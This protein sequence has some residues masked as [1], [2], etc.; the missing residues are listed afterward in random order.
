[1]SALHKI[2][3]SQYLGLEDSPCF[4][5]L[6][7]CNGKT[8]LLKYLSQQVQGCLLG[9]T[10]K[11]RA[12]SAEQQALYPSFAEFYLPDALSSS[13]KPLANEIFEALPSHLVLRGELSDGKYTCPAQE[14]FEYFWDS[15][16]YTKALFEADGSR[17]LPLKAYKDYEP[18]IDSRTT[19]TISILPLEAFSCEISPET[20]CR[21]ELF[22][23]R[24]K[25]WI[26]SNKTSSSAL[27]AQLICDTKCIFKDAR[28][29]KI[30]L[31]N[32]LDT[33]DDRAR[34]QQY[35]DELIS[36]LKALQHP[37]DFDIIFA[38]IQAEYYG[39]YHASKKQD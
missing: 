5:S 34:A 21:Y 32:K 37:Q 11:M 29:K 4:I 14:L 20:V 10:T 25:A 8:S 6:M 24:Y 19:H 27:I 17:G 18:V 3:L 31:I 16:L 35:C 33:A 26:P 9:C 15:G 36:E 1:M 38:S 28:G 30:L 22:T 23:Q 2:E 12:F 39:V 7:G 13:H